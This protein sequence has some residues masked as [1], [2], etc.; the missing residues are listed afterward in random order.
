[1]SA[2]FSST[3]PASLAPAT[4]SCIRLR[5][6]RNVDFPH[7]DGPMSAVTVAAGIDS[8]TSSRT[9]LSPNQAETPTASSREGPVASGA[10]RRR[11]EAEAPCPT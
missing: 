7:P 10:A 11:D 9:R 8:E 5:I 3:S 6:R 4:D 2:P 1:M